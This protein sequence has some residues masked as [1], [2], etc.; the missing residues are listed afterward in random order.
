MTKDLTKLQKIIFNI[1]DDEPK[2]FVDICMETYL[3][4]S[5]WKRLMCSLDDEEIQ[6]ELN[7]LRAKGLVRRHAQDFQLNRY[8]KL[9]KRDAA[10]WVKCEGIVK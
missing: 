3:N 9:N 8:G 7:I 4:V 2:P 1:L 10:L 6:D 5:W